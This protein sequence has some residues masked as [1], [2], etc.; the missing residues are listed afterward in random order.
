MKLSEYARRVGVQYRTAWNWY[1]AG[2]IKGYQTE[3]GTIIITELDG[4]SRPQSS[5][6]VLYARVS[7]HKQKA[8]LERQGQRLQ[9]YCA[10][11]GWQVTRVVKEIASG[12]NDNRHKL[13]ELLADETVT[14]IVVEHKDRLTRV[15]FGYIETLFVNQGR[16]IIVIN[17]AENDNDDLLEDLASII[18]SFCARLYGKRRAQ[19]KA[20]LVKKIVQNE[21]EE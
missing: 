3:T 15:G 19:K 9:D 21:D 16:E 4:A 5:K 6:T 13:T 10:A 2:K 7:S 17:L 18:Y 1:R 8:D 20:E 12:V 14:R 11:K